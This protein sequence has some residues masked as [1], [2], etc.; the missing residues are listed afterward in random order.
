[1]SIYFGGQEYEK[2]YL[3]G[4]EI[5]QITVANETYIPA[6]A[7]A[8]TFYDLMPTLDRTF[9]GDTPAAGG[10]NTSPL[11]FVHD[12]DTWQLW[13]TIPYLGVGVTSEANRGRCRLHLR[14]TSIA[15]DAMTLG[16]M[17]SSLILTH[18]S[19]TNSPWTFT[20]PTSSATF[21][22]PGGGN[23]ARRS[24]DYIPVRTPQAAASVEG[25]VQGQ[26]F[27][28]RLIFS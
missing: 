9:S 19:W 7:P 21:G 10:G 20:R 6:P 15:R 13:Q 25:I 14:D 4:H 22:S 5:S 27:T 23:A 12:G 16:M 3:G 11:T 26:T 17:P 28:I 1:M 8:E 18:A 2:A 24:L